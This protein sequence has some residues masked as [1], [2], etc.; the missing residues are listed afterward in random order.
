MK[1]IS[2]IIKNNKL[3]AA[4]LAFVLIM[5]FAALIGVMSEKYS[6]QE[7]VGI[8]EKPVVEKK[9]SGEEKVSLFNE[10]NVRESQEKQTLI[11]EKNIFLTMVLAIINMIMLFVILV[12]LILDVFF[13]RRLMR[14][15]ELISP[16]AGPREEPGW[17]M[18]DV[19]KVCLIFMSSGGVVL[20]LQDFIAK[21]FP[22]LKNENFQ[23]IFNTAI[24]NFAGIS[25][26]LYFVVKKY[27]QNLSAIGLTAK[28]GM[29][30][31]FYSLAGYVA[32]VPVLLVVMMLTYFVIK[33]LKYT[34]PV[35]PIVKVLMEEK[36]TSVLL[37]STLFA[38]IFGPIAEEIFFRGFMY[39]AVK[40]R[41]GVFAAMIGTA[42]IFAV[43]HGHLVGFLPIMALGLLLAYLYE[44]TG[45][46][47]SSICVHVMHNVATV[48]LVFIMRYAAG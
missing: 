40:K 8:E 16:D 19:A 15:K 33:V 13:V 31:V 24:M 25:V 17:G 43:L 47:V 22:I 32:L 14:K 28:N 39:S 9:P 44:K 46:L 41:F 36:E 6:A 30:N 1:K 34:P 10:Q 27:G 7:T 48:V 2:T 38:A 4:L 26:I 18:A 11:S 12:G 3:Y 29:K 45:S 23:M 5:N 37:V 42:A 21:F 20:F 35:Q